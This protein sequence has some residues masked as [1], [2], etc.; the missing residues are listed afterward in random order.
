VGLGLAIVRSILDAHEVEIEV[1][2]LPGR[3]TTFRFALPVAPPQAG[4]DPGLLPG[5][6]A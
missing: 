4:P 6:G 3:G 2:S 5:T 1:E